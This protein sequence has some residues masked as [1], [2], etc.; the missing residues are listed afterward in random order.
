MLKNCNCIK[1]SNG[2]DKIH[3]DRFSI[4]FD[5]VCG[6]RFLIL[7]ESKTVFRSVLTTGKKS[8]IDTTGSVTSTRSTNL[9]RIN[10]IYTV[11]STPYHVTEI[12]SLFIERNTRLLLIC[13]L[14]VPGEFEE[15]STEKGGG[16]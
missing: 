1:E 8:L 3:G 4:V 2:K 9:S 15:C 6:V 7:Y 16:G 11:T 12:R 5:G 13:I 14:S 10:V